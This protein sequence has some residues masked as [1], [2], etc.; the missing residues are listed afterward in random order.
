MGKI[1]NNVVTKGFS[2]QFGDEL[3]FRQ[4][5]KKTIFARKGISTKAPTAGQ[6]NTR[7]KFT[8]AAYFATAALDNPISMEDY[9]QMA[10]LQ[11]LKSAYVAALT[12][13]LTAP[14]IGKV[15]TALYKGKVGDMINISSKSPFKIT[16]ID[17]TI[18][19]PNGTVLESGKAEQNLLRYRYVATVANP[20]V[21]GTKIVLKARDR[22]GIEQIVEVV[23]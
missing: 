4:L 1:K 5:D 12:D 17:V 21:T 23:L 16:E 8:D 10:Q 11:G 19:A 15:Y 7:N 13:Y 22:Q 3:V 6:V 9:T 18:L 14:E 2:G 20:T